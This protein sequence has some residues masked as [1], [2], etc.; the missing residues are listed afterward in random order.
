MKRRFVVQRH[1]VS[2]AEVH[3]DLM[4]ERGPAE[5]LATF[6]LASPLPQ[7]AGES[8]PGERSFDHRRAYLEFEG[9]I[10]GNRGTVRIVAR[11]ELEDLA[12]GPDQPHWSLRGENGTYEVVGTKRVM[13]TR[14]SGSEKV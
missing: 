4:I 10:S 8:V 13:V 5:L 7:R 14:R 1:E 3:F 11:G 9:P 2:Q 12:G 6:R